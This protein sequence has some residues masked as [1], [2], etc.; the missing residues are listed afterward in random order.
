MKLLFVCT[1]NACRSILGEV[2]ASQLGGSRIEAASAGSN[3]AG[4]VH[5]LTLQYLNE[6]G[7]RIDGLSSKGFDDVQSFNPDVVITVCDRA[8]NESCPLWLGTAV[9]GHWGLPDPSHCEGTEQERTAAFDAVATKLN[10]R[11]EALLAEPFEELDA[12]QLAVLLNA[13]AEQH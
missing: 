9:K 3:P 11:I 1:H 13:I 2:I 8:A 10:S 6:R 5:P 4:R 12:A 7:Y